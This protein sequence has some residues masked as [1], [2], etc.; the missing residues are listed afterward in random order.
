MRIHGARKCNSTEG[1][2]TCP[3]EPWS[4]GTK[5]DSIIVSVLSN[6]TSNLSTFACDV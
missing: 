1:F 4:F 5:A 2:S 6:Y 3:N